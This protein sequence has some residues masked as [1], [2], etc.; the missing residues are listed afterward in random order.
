MIRWCDPPD[1]PAF[2]VRMWLS[3]RSNMAVCGSFGEDKASRNCIPEMVVRRT[4]RSCPEQSSVPC[5]RMLSKQ[6][7]RFGE[8]VGEADI[9]AT[10]DSSTRGVLWRRPITHRPSACFWRNHGMQTCRTNLVML[11]ICSVMGELAIVCPL[12]LLCCVV[13]SHDVCGFSTKVSIWMLL[14]LPCHKRLNGS[15]MAPT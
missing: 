1:P 14:V 9:Q 10:D 8:R 2:G 11:G 3:W 4:L 5:L 7:L 13:V 12:V 6:F 15:I